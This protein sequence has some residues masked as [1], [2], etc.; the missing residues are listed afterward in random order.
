M[1]VGYAGYYVCRSDYSVSIP[2][3][4]ADLSAHGMARDAAKID[5][6]RIASLAVLGYALGKFVSGPLADRL[7]GRRLFLGGMLGSIL[8]TIAFA[9]GGGIP[10]FTLAWIANRLVQSTGWVG[11]V[12]L[13][14]KWFSYAQYGTAMG[15][16]SVSYL[17]GDVGA[18]LFMEFLIDHGIGWRGLFLAA[19]A[20]LGVLLL[21]NAIWLREAPDVPPADSPETLGAFWRSSQFWLA[22]VL[23]LGFTLIRE[24]FNTWTPTFFTE[25]AS[26]SPAAAAGASA[27][28]PLLGACSVVLAGIASDVLGRSGRARIMFFGLLASVG[29][30]LLLAHTRMWPVGLVAATGFTVLG[31]YSYLAGATSLDFGG[32]R[33][34]ATTCGIIDGVGYLGGVLAGDSMARV[35][36][37][38]GWHGAFDVL[39]GV[40]GVTA[41]AA[42]ALIFSQ[43]Q[44]GYRR[45]DPHV[46]PST[47]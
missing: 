12:K 11:M 20:V 33:A 22:C 15:V 10:I 39:A 21:V 18:R 34:S 43:E 32:Q 27:W 19:A 45:A 29:L 47:R 3:L 30:L 42:L 6:G 16:I 7:G 28:F 4:I 44:H 46:V 26:L 40:A 8:F 38:L 9:L 2:L 13:T 14:S 1:V 23:S 24:T 17:L 35:S 37:A 5:L 41:I 25:A 31:P 36:V